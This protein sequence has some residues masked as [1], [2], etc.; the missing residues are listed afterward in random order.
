MKKFVLIFITVISFSKVSLAADHEHSAEVCSVVNKQ[1]CAHIGHMKGFTTKDEGQ[2]VFHVFTPSKKSVTNLKLDLWMAAHGHG[3]SPV[4]ITDD[5][6]N[7]FKVKK[8]V[9]TMT[10]KWT[11]RATFDVAGAT[12]KI[13]IP[14]EILK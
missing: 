4:E 14:V 12:H 5:G 1:V 3:T 10:G 13:E 2:F 11:V 8:T 6:A 7:K 9:F